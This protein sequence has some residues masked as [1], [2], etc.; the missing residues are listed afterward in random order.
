MASLYEL[1]QN[2]LVLQEMLES[3]EINETVY[4]DT[5]EGMGT[6]EK[7]ENV[8]KMIRN[9][10]AKA[11]AF[12]EEKARLESKQKTAENGVKRLKESLLVHLHALNKKKVDAGLFT[13]SLS[14]TTS[15]AVTHPDWLISDYLIPQEPK[16][17]KKKI[18]DDLKAGNEVAGAE[19]ATKE[20][21]R[22]K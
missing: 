11:N 17:D 18:A 13:V 10:E 9:L 2:A 7:I 21:V 1:T 22:I 16:I 15:V 19:L 20:Y 4:A 3:G 14:K 5:L 8:C 12:K 6:D